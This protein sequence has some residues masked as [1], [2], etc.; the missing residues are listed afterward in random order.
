M[1]KL[2]WE[3]IVTYLN[4]EK[5]T[6]YSSRVDKVA[7]VNGMVGILANDQIKSFEVKSMR[8]E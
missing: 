4:G 6:Y 8:D 7:A 3:I 1:E 5:D 2:Y